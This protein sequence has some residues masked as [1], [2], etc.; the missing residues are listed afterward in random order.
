MTNPSETIDIFKNGISSSQSSDSSLSFF[1][2]SFLT[3]SKDK[4]EIFNLDKNSEALKVLDTPLE[5][6][7]YSYFNYC[8]A[9]PGERSICTEYASVLDFT[10]R[11][12]GIN[13]SF[14]CL[15][16]SVCFSNFKNEDRS[17]ENM[18]NYS[19]SNFEFNKKDIFDDTPNCFDIDTPPNSP[20]VRSLRSGKKVTKTIFEEQHDSNLVEK[21]Q[22]IKQKH[23]KNITLGYININS[24]R[25]K[26]NDLKLLLKDCL[27]IFIIA[28]TKIDASFPTGQFLMQEY[29]RPFRL[30][31][32]DKSGGLLMYIRKG[33][34]ARPLY[35][36]S[37]CDKMQVLS[38]ELHLKTSKWLL[39]SIYRP[40]YIKPKVFLAHLDKIIGLHVDKLKNMIIIGDFNMLESNTDL[41]EF[42]TSHKLY[43]LIKSPTCFKSRENPTAID[44]IFTNRKYS[45]ME[46]HTIETGLSDFHQLILTC[47]KSTFVKLPPKKLEYR[48]YGK[49]DENKFLS[50]I[51]KDLD[52]VPLI[53]Y[54]SLTLV[55]QN[56][57]EKHAP[58]KTKIVRG[59]DKAHMNKTLRKEIMHRSKLKNIANKTK[60][61]NDIK[62]Y[63]K[64]RNKCVF[65]N[66]EARK[67]SMKNVD[68]RGIRNTKNFWKTYK[69][70][71]SHNQVIDDKIILVEKNK[72]IS[73]D[74]IISEIF[75]EYFTNI[76]NSLNISR[77][78]SDN[79]TETD[80]IQI[81]IH[82]YRFHPSILKIKATIPKDNKNFFFTHVLPEDVLKEINNLK[83]SKKT[84][85]KIPIKIIKILQKV[86]LNHLTDC[87]NS[88][89]IEG[90]FPD[91][92]KLADIT[93][94]FK[95]DDPTFKG[96]YRPISILEAYSKVYERIL[97]NQIN[98]YMCDKL[99]NKLCG[100]RKGHSTQHL[101][102]KLIEKWRKRLDSGGIV[103]T[104]LM[105]L[106][107]AFDSLPHDLL[108]AKLEAYGFSL[109]ALKLMNDYLNNRFQRVKIGSKFSTWRKIIA[110]IPQGSVLGPL[111]FNIFINDIFL[112][113]LDL[114]NF[115]DDNTIDACSDDVESMIVKLETDILI[116]LKW[117]KN[118]SLVANP[119]K[120]QMMFLGVK[121]SENYCLEIP[122]ANY[123]KDKNN[124]KFLGDRWLQ[125]TGN[126]IIKSRSNVKLLGVI[127]ENKLNFNLHIDKLCVKAKKV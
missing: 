89:I 60:D 58:T 116:A 78:P 31:I 10:N 101:L 13:G 121:D 85:G 127:I 29:N 123:I 2:L 118:N 110:G 100:F 1:N 26:F 115:A 34:A 45:F 113:L 125:I 103:G 111:L 5:N 38:V 17:I 8:E 22:G 97:V 102:L 96:C 61:T 30:D 21:I 99:S 50:D 71:L 28:E 47:M 62:N 42:I 54:Q 63:K 20:C 32:S 98:R 25:N 93:A 82:K 120:F 105:D 79:K 73:D 35:V 36:K 27:D 77:W 108:I 24:I 124:V 80:P 66:K 94:A 65:L 12:K 109:L 81:A 72:I 126:I 14:S 44:H 11:L 84:R 39:L 83:T 37:E 69:P 112:H 64:Q 59:N 119:A 53:N 70:Y 23:V 9:P 95:A 49:F 52:K 33:I 48:D 117:F 74:S 86:S 75:N 76:T 114:T 7:S 4:S 6:E 55:T 40:E 15:S 41:S 106:S 18:V 19:P 16:K 51:V 68:V 56:I 46:S 3:D 91:E 122:N 87:L 43:N 107:K 67:N 88:A 104:I 90:K 92:L 57:L